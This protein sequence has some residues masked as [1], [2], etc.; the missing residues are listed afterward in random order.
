MKQWLLPAIFF[1]G[2]LL[3]TI[4]LSS[5][6]AGFTP[7]EAS[8]GYDA[9]SIFKTGKDQWGHSFPLVLESLGDFKPPLYSYILVPF[10]AVFGL[11]EWVVRLPNAL[12]GSLAVMATYYLVL[13]LGKFG[14]LRKLSITDK[15]SQLPTANCQLLASISAALLAVSP[16]HIMMSRG[17]F[18]ANMT[19]FLMPLGILLF[20]KRLKMSKY[21]VFSSVVLG[22]NMFSYHSARLI[23]PLLVGVMLILYC[24]KLKDLSKTIRN[25]RKVGIFIVIFSLFTAVSLYTFSQGAG[26]RVTDISVLGGA[27]E[28]AAGPRLDAIN[29]GMN[30][31]LAKILNNKYQIAIIRFANNYRQYFSVKFLFANGP[32]EATYGMIPG[33]GVLYWFEWILFVGFVASLIRPLRGN[34]LKGEQKGVFLIVAWILMAPIP[35]ALAIGPGYAGNRSVIMLPAIQILLALGFYFWYQLAKKYNYQKIFLVFATFIYLVSFRNFLI[36]YTKDQP[37]KYAE[38][39]LYGRREMVQYLLDNGYDLMSSAVVIDKRLSE[40]QMHIAFYMKIDPAQFQIW[41]RQWQTYRE[42]KVNFIDQLDEYRMGKY[43]FT[44]N[45]KEKKDRFGE[46]DLLVGKPEEFEENTVPLHT[47]KYPNGEDAIYFVD[48]DKN[49]YAFLK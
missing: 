8:F 22:L 7:D 6:P 16:W 15:K 37:Q 46:K 48:P 49:A 35:A 19:T 32:A 43:L 17:G 14:G 11:S 34:P 28:S 31:I 21:L 3:R 26:V 29:S 27:A 47:I 18:E 41:T 39:M 4:N 1:L 10:V 2:L 13:E 33:M 36:S 40:P 45:F 25:F 12:L 23:V 38:A 20:I 30:P 44:T 24:V 9:Y 42:K 5:F